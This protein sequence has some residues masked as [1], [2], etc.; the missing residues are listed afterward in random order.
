MGKGGTRREKRHGP[1]GQQL[2]QLRGQ[3]LP[4]AMRS[5]GGLSEDKQLTI[6]SL[7]CYLFPSLFLSLDIEVKG[8]F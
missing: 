8:G 4:S 7:S 5:P 1:A 6:R 3:Q 2:D